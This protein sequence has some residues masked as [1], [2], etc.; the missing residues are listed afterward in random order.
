M[1]KITF[2]QHHFAFPYKFMVAN[3]HVLYLLCARGSNSNLKLYKKFVVCHEQKPIA[4]N[5]FTSNES[6]ADVYEEPLQFETF[7]QWWGC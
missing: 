6:I 3:S 2:Y 4:I 5:V 7:H 1:H